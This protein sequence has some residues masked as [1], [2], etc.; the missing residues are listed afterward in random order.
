M[1]GG[2]DRI[3]FGDH[4]GGLRAEVG[5]FGQGFELCRLKLQ[6]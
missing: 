5:S 4:I 3:G 6:R 2:L 1:Y